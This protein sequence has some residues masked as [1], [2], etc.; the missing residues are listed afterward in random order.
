MTS[1]SQFRLSQPFFSSFL[2]NTDDED[3]EGEDGADNEGEDGGDNGG[4][5]GGEDGGD[6]G[7]ED[8]GNEAG[9]C[10]LV[11]LLQL[12]LCRNQSHFVIL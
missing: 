4:D 9:T 6:N 5:N 12:Y 2:L 10:P 7:A 1:G 11:Y 8:G 3:N